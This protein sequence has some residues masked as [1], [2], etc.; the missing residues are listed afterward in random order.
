MAIELAGHN[1]QRITWN[2]KGVQAW[3]VDSFQTNRKPEDQE[4]G[5]TM[6]SAK[7]ANFFFNFNW[8]RKVDRLLYLD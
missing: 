3:E 6:L 7:N 1:N 2:R 5:Q 8:R 4:N